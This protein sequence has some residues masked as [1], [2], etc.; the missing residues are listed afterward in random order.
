VTGDE[1]RQ[2]GTEDNEKILRTIGE[3]RAELELAV[4]TAPPRALE[5]IV[6]LHRLE[7]LLANRVPEQR[8]V[9]ER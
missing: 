4:L 5:L 3:I 7:S 8:I 1:V 6:E 2:M 9:L